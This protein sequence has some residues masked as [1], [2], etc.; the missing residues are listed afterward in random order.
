MKVGGNM[1]LIDNSMGY[2][3]VHRLETRLTGYEQNKLENL[4]ASYNM[5]KSEFVR[6]R[7]FGRAID[8]AK[9]EISNAIEKVR[10]GYQRAARAAKNYFSEP[11]DIYGFAY[12]QPGYGTSFGYR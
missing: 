2:R 4:A 8:Y 1:S 3:R 7:L 6:Q 12:A 9:S 10:N 5:D 11:D